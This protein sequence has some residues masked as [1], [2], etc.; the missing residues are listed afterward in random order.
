[1]EAPKEPPSIS[2][3]AAIAYAIGLPLA[4]LALVFLPAGSLSWAPGWVFLAVLVLGFGIS[5]LVLARVNPMIYRARSR[6]QPGTKGWDKALLAV[7]LPMMVA[8][9]PVAALDAG[10]YRWSEVPGWLVVLGYVAVLA[11]IAVTAWA[12]AVNP[13]FEPGVRIQSERRQL[14]IDTGPYRFVRHPGYS[15]ALALFLGMALALTSFWA[16]APATLASAFLVLRTSWEDRLL[17][18]ELS[19]YADYARRIRWRLFPGLW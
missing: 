17:Q 14:V 19:G 8:I 3:R 16:L 13:F 6:I 5:A 1:M 10:R 7:I 12:Q 11:G 4:L 9:L 2:P 18:A 15:A